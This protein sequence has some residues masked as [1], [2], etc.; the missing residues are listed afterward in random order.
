MRGAAAGLHQSYHP[1]SF[2]KCCYM[3]YNVYMM[4]KDVDQYH[5]FECP[6]DVFGCFFH[7]LLRVFRVTYLNTSDVF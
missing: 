4:F 3:F 7:V 1:Q 2:V 5:I 6:F